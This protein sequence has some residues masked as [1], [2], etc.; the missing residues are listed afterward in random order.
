MLALVD[1][2]QG[3]EL[4]G[5]LY[6]YIDH[7]RCGIRRTKYDLDKAEARAHILEGLLIALD[8][9]DEVINLIRSSRMIR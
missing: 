2:Q 1:G 4:K 9:I 6:H 3:N 5:D 7:Q 8:H